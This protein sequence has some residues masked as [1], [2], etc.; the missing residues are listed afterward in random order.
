VNTKLSVAAEQ[1]QHM[2]EAVFFEGPDVSRKLSRFWILL[3][4]AAVIAATGVVSDSTA[5]VIGAMIVAPLMIPI[6]GTMLAAVLGD[7]ANLARSIG[8]VISAAAA[9]TAIGFAIAALVP[10]DV[11]AATNSQ[12]AA[13]VNPTLLD[14]LAAFAT[15]AVG[16]IALVRRDISDTLPGVAIAISLVPPL[17]VVGITL[18]AGEPGQAWGALLLFLTNVTAILAVGS[19]VMAIYKV[20]AAG[21]IAAIDAGPNT[22]RRSP[23]VIAAMLVLVAIPLTTSSLLL[24]RQRSRENDVYA[25]SAE[26]AG[27]RDWEVVGVST[28]EGDT[29]VRLTGPLPVPDPASLR[30]ALAAD[31]IDVATVRAEFVPSETVNLGE[32]DG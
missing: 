32:I 27:D 18:E 9:A 8:L 12:V 7:R 5:T 13:R 4:L 10:N 14:L 20:R 29:I 25:A 15:G 6:Q 30:D 3:T 2:R 17:T 23:I 16:S 21:G 1:V 22:H 19:I 31:G 28:K 24:V 26:W 11:T